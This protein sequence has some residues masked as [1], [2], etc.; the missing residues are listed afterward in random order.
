MP[1][2]TS[3]TSGS[4][5]GGGSGSSGGSPGAGG[6]G[7]LTGF[8]SGTVSCF[9]F[10]FG[11]GGSGLDG[12]ADLGVAGSGESFVASSAARAGSMTA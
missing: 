3:T 11:S 9:E 2:V 5:G 12:S 1:A 8:G 10:C 6:R 4:G 7:V